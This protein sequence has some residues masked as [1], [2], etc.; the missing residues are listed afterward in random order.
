[1][2]VVETYQPFAGWPMQSERVTQAVGSRHVCLGTLDF[3]L[4]P[5]APLQQVIRPS[6]ASRNSNHSISAEDMFHTSSVRNR[7]LAT[8][9]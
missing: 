5:I 6:K 4:E 3:E 8:E 1:M 7:P 9:P 2:G